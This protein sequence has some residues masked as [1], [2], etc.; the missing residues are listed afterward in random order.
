MSESKKITFPRNM[1]LI[2]RITGVSEEIG[3]WLDSLEEPF[4]VD[5]DTMHLVKCERNDHYS[6][7]YILDRA[8]KEPTKRPPSRK[9]PKSGMQA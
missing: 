4:D 5:R 2:D 1:S 6:Y 8:V 9:S 7:H 3:K